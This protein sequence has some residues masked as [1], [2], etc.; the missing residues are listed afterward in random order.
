VFAVYARKVA[1]PKFLEED[2][3]SRWGKMYP[4]I[5]NRSLQAEFVSG[6]WG[7]Q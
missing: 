1:H 7:D 3:R 2:V 6:I 5:V 4:V